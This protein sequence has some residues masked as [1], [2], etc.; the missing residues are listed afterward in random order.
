MEEARTISK[1]RTARFNS[2]NALIDD[3]EKASVGASKKARQQ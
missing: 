3:L 2:A 1:A